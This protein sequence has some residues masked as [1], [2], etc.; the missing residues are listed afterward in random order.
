MSLL[1]KIKKNTSAVWISEIYPTIKRF[2]TVKLFSLTKLWIQIPSDS[3]T[4]ITNDREISNNLNNY[5]NEITKLCVSLLSKRK[6]STSA[7]WISEMYPTIKRFMKL[8]NLFSL[9]RL[10]IQIPS[11]TSRIITNK[12]EISSIWKII[13]LK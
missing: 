13:L 4:I 2:G 12:R 11:D 7:T 8:K 1:S 9:K 10:W 6:K 5:F 3:T